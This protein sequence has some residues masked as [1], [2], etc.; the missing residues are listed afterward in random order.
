MQAQDSLRTLVKAMGQKGD[1]AWS[2]AATGSFMD[3]LGLG[4]ILTV[5]VE[6]I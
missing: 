5:D 1:S 2:G 3:K 6:W 4:E